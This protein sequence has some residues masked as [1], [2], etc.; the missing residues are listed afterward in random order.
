MQ[1]AVKMYGK[2]PPRE[3][4][5]SCEGKRVRVGCAKPMSP[6]VR[7]LGQGIIEG[8]NF[9]GARCFYYLMVT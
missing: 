3:A 7:R 6:P 4:T 2:K 9:A 5:L 8:A 1:N